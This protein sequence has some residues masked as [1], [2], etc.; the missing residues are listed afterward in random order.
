M[1]GSSFPSIQQVGGSNRGR[2][3]PSFLPSNRFFREL[4]PFV[5]SYLRQTH[6]NTVPRAAESWNEQVHG[7]LFNPDAV[8]TRSVSVKNVTR[9]NIRKHSPAVNVC[10]SYV[11]LLPAVNGA[12][13]L[14]SHGLDQYLKL[15]SALASPWRSSQPVSPFSPFYSPSSKS[16][17]GSFSMIQYADRCYLLLWDAA[18]SSPRRTLINSTER[19]GIPQ[20]YPNG[21]VEA[22]G[23]ITA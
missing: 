19:N 12:T 11:P 22:L 6:Y 5:P 2:S 13:M 10:S 7:P 9:D 3:L 8:R 1:S 14:R 17:I 20:N 21:L 4:K 15:T 16:T 18:A 23:I